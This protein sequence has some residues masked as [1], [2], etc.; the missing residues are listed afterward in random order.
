[1]ARSVN[2]SA[3]ASVLAQI[4]SQPASTGST[5]LVPQ[6]WGLKHSL[7]MPRVLYQAF[8]FSH[9]A[10]SLPELSLCIPLSPPRKIFF[11]FFSNLKQDLGHLQKQLFPSLPDESQCPYEWPPGLQ[12][13]HL[14]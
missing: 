14:I 12:A 2:L 10:L 13:V 1:M 5:H 11:F 6:H 7:A 8:T 4:G 9:Q 3:L